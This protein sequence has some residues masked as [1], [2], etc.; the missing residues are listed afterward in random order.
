[1]TE[2]DA[3][4]PAPGESVTSIVVFDSSGSMSGNDPAAAGRR[5]AGTAYFGSRGERDRTAVIDFGA[6]T[7]HSL[8]TSRLLQPFTDDKESLMESLDALVD[9]GGTPL[10][11]SLVDALDLLDEELPSGGTIVVLTDGQSSDAGLDLVIGRALERGTEIY[12]V[13]LGSTLGFGDLIELGQQTGGGMIRADNASA[14]SATFRGI[15]DG[16]SVGRVIVHGA[17]QFD[18]LPSGTLF[19]VTGSLLT[20]TPD[21]AIVTDFEFMTTLGQ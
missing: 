20:D 13:G 14:L 3:I 10:Y 16:V 21:G 4:A 15:S 12:A 2:V 19:Q 18:A 7:S 8:G 5:A 9:S 6:G 1:V 11:G 17:S